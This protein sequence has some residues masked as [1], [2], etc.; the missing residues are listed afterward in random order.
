MILVF[1]EI[2]GLNFCGLNKN[3]KKNIEFRALNEYS[4]QIEDDND[5][6]EDNNEDNNEGKTINNENEKMDLKMVY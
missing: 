3:I 6:D 1:L 2:I 5:D 4:L